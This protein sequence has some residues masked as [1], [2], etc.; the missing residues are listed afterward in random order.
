MHKQIRVF[1]V[2][3]LFHPQLG[4]VGRQAVGLAEYLYAAGVD[5][6]VL[7]RDIAG[8]PA[9][10]PPP[11]LRIIQHKTIWPHRHDLEAK[12][13]LNVLISLSFCFGLMYSL[14]R[15]RSEYDIA[16]FHGAGLPLIVNVLPLAWMGKKIL[17][18]VAGAKMNREAGSFKGKFFGIGAIFIYMLRNVDAFIAVS[19]EIRNDLLQDEFEEDRI[20]SISNFVR[21]DVFYPADR[22]RKQA[23]RTILGIDPT[24]VV[25]LCSGRL[26]PTKRIDVLLRAVSLI[27]PER[28]EIQVIILGQGHAEGSL[29]A[30]AADLHIDEN[31]V[32]KGFVSNIVDYLQASDLFV[33]TSEVEGMPNALL[34]AM[35]CRLPV[36]ATRIGGVVDIVKDEENGI[37]AEPGDAAA[38]RAAIKALLD[39]PGRR[40]CLADG[41]Y[42]TILRQYS[43]ETVAA[44]YLGLYRRVLGAS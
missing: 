26:V 22:E 43:I 23:L 28:K 34:E 35:A 15:R 18:K 6:T 11:G 8:V 33:F 14:I 16:H 36:I 10:L 27:L 5:V 24:K 17:A 37:L 12:S 21:T 44:G 31:V 1:L 41:A 13:L 29:Q 25:L 2:S 7:C 39:D 3:P 30:M 4:G 9:W 19:E 38:L 40:A 32:F 42:Q 20:F